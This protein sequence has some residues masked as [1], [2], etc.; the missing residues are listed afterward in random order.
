[1]KYLG[2]VVLT[3]IMALSQNFTVS[4]SYH[5]SVDTYLHLKRSSIGFAGSINLSSW[6]NRDN[7]IR[8]TGAYFMGSTP[9]SYATVSTFDRSEYSVETKNVLV[10]GAGWFTV[11]Q[12]GYE[13]TRMRQEANN[14]VYQ[15][16]EYGWFVT[17]G[18]GIRI[19]E[20]LAVTAR[21][22]G[23]RSNEG[24]RFALEYDF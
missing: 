12:V 4:S 9:S 20:S 8:L 2:L 15:Y 6:N 23:G 3:P 11:L 19:K 17:A 13:I 14:R 1:M 7:T 16:V 10:N 24:T 5:L 18:I 22:L 21:Y